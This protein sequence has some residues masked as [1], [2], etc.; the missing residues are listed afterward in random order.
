[1]SVFPPLGARLAL[2]AGLSL[3]VHLV[4]ISSPVTDYHH[5]R[6]ANTAAI[7]RNYRDDG[8]RFLHPRINW[9]GPDRGRA[10]TEFPLY[11]YLTGALWD[12]F[13]LGEIWGRILSA[14]FSAATAAFLLVFLEGWIGARAAFFGSLLF[15]LI[16]VEVFFGR[17]VQPEAL[18]LFCTVAALLA[19]DRYLRARTDGRPGPA[20][21]FWCAAWACASLAIGHKIP[22]A[23]LL[24]VLAVLAWARQ[25]RRAARDLGSWAL[26]PLTA[27]AVFAWYR[28]ASSGTYVVPTEKRQFLAL[29]EY[30]RLPYFVFFQF[31]SRFPELGV[32][33]PGMVLW[34]AGVKTLLQREGPER[35]FLLGY[36]GC[37]AAYVGAGGNYI[38][39]HD[40]T[41]L[42]WAP[43]NA[44]LLGL[45]LEAL[46]DRAESLAPQ[47]RSRARAALAALLAAVPVYTAVRIK[48]WYGVKDR[49]LL[50]A[51]GPVSRIS[52]PEDL[53]LC[54]ERA[55]S[56]LLYYIRRNGW[57]ADITELKEPPLD[58]L[59]RW[60]SRGAKFYM[61]RRSGAFLD[62]EHP[63]A[64]PVYEAFPIA[65]EDGDFL[66]FSLTER[67]PP[68]IVTPGM[69]SSKGSS[70][71][72]SKPSR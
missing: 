19:F 45:G 56:L 1:M 51:A 11:M 52:A 40:Y 49:F 2:A 71:S 60:S 47:T 20:A 72:G 53:F 29:L 31:F 6:Q 13:G 24:G 25:G 69:S 16:P 8:L 41:A 36:L 12:L 18:A 37:V 17:T 64:K 66:V 70:G 23:Y 55:E 42:P 7:A 68:E 67:T 65:Y 62:R 15:S 34:A 22:Y 14:L 50:S 27:L 57:S 35:S 5:H 54:N 39:A 9:A 21:G 32:G 33:W 58:W 48:H 59:A 63:L 3:A 10:A 28:Y 38:H 26:F 30:H 4:G 43:V 46:L 61:T 44:A